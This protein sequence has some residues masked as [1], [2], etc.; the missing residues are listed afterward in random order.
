[1][2][3]HKVVAGRQESILAALGIKWPPAHGT[4]I[5][6]PFADHVDKDPSWRWDRQKER[7]FC[8]CTPQGGSVFDAVMRMRGCTFQEAS[9]FAA[10]VLGEKPRQK[11]Q[12]APVPAL[13]SLRHIETKL[14]PSGVW[15]YHNAAGEFVMAEARYNKE[16]GGKT[17]LPWT[18]TGRRWQAKGLPAP[19]P[20][21]RLP[22]ILADTAAP[23]LIVEG[24]KAADRATE[25]FP[26]LI[27][28][29]ASGGANAAHLTD[30]APLKGRRVIIW[31][32]HDAAGKRYADECAMRAYDAGAAEI[33]VVRVPD[34]YPPKWDLGDV[35][36]GEAGCEIGRMLETAEKWRPES[37]VVDLGA[38][39]LRLVHSRRKEDREELDEYGF[40]VD[41][42]TGAIA[43]DVHNLGR[44]LELMG[45]RLSYNEFAGEYRIDGLSGYGPVLTDEASGTLYVSLWRKYNLKYTQADF[46]LMVE[47]AARQ[48]GFHPVRQ[49]LDLQDWDG[50]ERVEE[51]LSTYLGAEDDGV[52]RQIAR[53][54]LIA[55]VRRIRKPGCKFDCMTVIEGPQGAGK[56]RAVAALCPDAGWFTDA[57]P[58]VADAKQVIEL[59]RGKWIVEVGELQGIRRAEVEHVK[60]LLDRQKDE[61]RLAYGRARA[62]VARQCVFI[63]TTNATE[64]L[65]DDT[66]NR[67][68]LPVKA[69]KIDVESLARDRDQLWAEAA[70]WEAQGEAIHPPKGMLDELTH[71][72]SQRLVADEFDTVIHPWLDE[73]YSTEAGMFDKKETTLIEVAGS[74]L[75]LETGRL[76]AGLQARIAKSMR[77]AGWEFSRKSNG[78]RLW[79]R[80]TD[81]FTALPP[82]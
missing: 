52:T 33:F 72:Q 31:P 75:S 46:H 13:L 74:A 67:R 12:A 51:W 59:T 25:L 80:K 39:R 57:L 4:H 65:L 60:K 44:A 8:T 53:M 14:L 78:R 50:I 7:W 81:T 43:H 61:A 5:N 41:R 15:V 82:C 6:C 77:R 62:S 69:G 26:H 3:A 48:N 9:E 24:G 47:D 10:E 18:W 55:A 68:F 71:R 36:K 45:V 17:F 66:G 63:G 64:Y 16:G 28:T 54:T 2:D 56:S 34:D 22:R 20:L 1:M 29:T 32:D 21:Y 79:K 58:L 70:H 35:E 40:H 23:V 73:H 49:Y 76:D 38:R 42:R 37:V 11:R 30:Y 19:R 27:C